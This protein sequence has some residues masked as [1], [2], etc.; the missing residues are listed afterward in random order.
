ML[1]KTIVAALMA[2]GIAA[3]AHAQDYPNQPVKMIVPF[4]AGGGNDVMARITSEF[5]SQRTKQQFIVENRPGAGSMIGL[6]FAA[7][8]KPDG[9]TLLW[10]PSDGITI[11]PAVKASVPY[12]VPEDFS[13]VARITQLPLIIVASP[14]APFKTFQEFLAYA[15]ANPGKVRYGS[16]GVGTAPHLVAVLFM[17]AAGIEATHIPY[18]GTGPALTALSGNHIDLLLPDPGSA[19]PF[20]EN[21][22][23]RALAVTDTVR[24]PSYPNVPT[25]EQAGL[26]SSATVFYGTFAPAGTPEPILQKLRG[27]MAEVLKDPKYVERIGQMGFQPS[28]L[29]GAE[30][31]DAIVKEL[32]Q[33]KGIAAAA[34]IKLAD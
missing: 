6:D 19:K 9:Y 12:K 7:R 23:I 27:E 15:K 34:N 30:F 14:Q 25:M 13:Y 33:W 22:S 32:E 29:A 2:F 21:N 18:Q 16:S 11:L 20:V 24:H 10:S 1:R 4:A 5:L 17:R 31:K 3:A 28:Y 26:A 8:Q